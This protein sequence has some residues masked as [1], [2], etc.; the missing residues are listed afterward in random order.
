MS[1]YR[2]YTGLLTDAKARVHSYKEAY[3][4]SAAKDDDSP[5]QRMQES[6]GN[7]KLKINRKERDESPSTI[8]RHLAAMKER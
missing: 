4:E 5:V 1:Q 6:E 3:K 7:L 8:S 2:Y